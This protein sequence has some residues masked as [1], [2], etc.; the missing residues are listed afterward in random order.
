MKK[1]LALLLTVVLVVLSMVACQPAE[2]TEEEKKDTPTAEV[3]PNKK[4]E[5]SMTYA[6]YMAAPLES[7]VVIEAFVQ[8]KQGWWN[9]KATLYLQDGDLHQDG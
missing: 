6:E 8:A 7:N 5:G 9:D 2:Q 4:S 3:D 1:F